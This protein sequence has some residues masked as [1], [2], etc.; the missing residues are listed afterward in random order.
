MPPVLTPEQK[1]AAALPT[2]PEGA[3]EVGPNLF[4]YTDPQGKTGCIARH[5]SA[6]SKWEEKP[7]EPAAATERAAPAAGSP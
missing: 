3:E 5:P 6:Y 1:A 2:V 4:R 7:G